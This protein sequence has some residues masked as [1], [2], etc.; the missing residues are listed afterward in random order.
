[1]LNRDIYNFDIV[2]VGAGVIG[3][4]IALACAKKNFSVLLLEKN[5]N[6]GQEI[7]SRNSEVIHAGIYYPENS[8]KAKFCRDGMKRLY[9]YCKEKSIPFKQTGKLIVQTNI[10]DQDKLLK[11][12]ETGRKN[13]CDELQLLTSKEVNKLES[14]ITAKNA[15]WSPK[16]GI[17]DSHQFMKSMLDDF[18]QAKGIV[19]YN[20]ELKEVINKGG[21]FE[22]P[23]EKSTFLNAKKIINCCGLHATNF[24]QYIKGFPKGLIKKTKFCKGT[25]FGYQG[26]IPF[27][28][29][30]YPIPSNVGLGIHFTLDLNNCGQFGPD[31]EWINSENYAVNNNR[32][33][34]AYN[35][36]KKYWPK[37]NKDKIRPVYAGIRPKIES[38]IDFEK[39]FLIQSV[40]DHKIP[41]L[42]NL[43]GIDSPGLTSALSIANK[44]VED[45][46]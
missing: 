9:Q 18:E 43:L 31:T 40:T 7:S 12:Y 37:C 6:F 46:I 23:L 24:T 26:K 22:L 35:E 16:T 19:V 3:I 32:V 8:L 17:I 1:M 45:C 30:I 15:I 38:K 29:H 28:H 5:S 42:I 39:D 27:N 14:E 13:G 2:V 34:N 4:S 25:Y 11:L 10:K 20:H 33:K 21:E 44:I 36:I 41:G